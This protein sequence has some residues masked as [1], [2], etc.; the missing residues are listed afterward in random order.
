MW[1]RSNET[2]GATGRFS[3]DLRKQ[4]DMVVWLG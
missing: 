4:V 1:G 2:G 3:T